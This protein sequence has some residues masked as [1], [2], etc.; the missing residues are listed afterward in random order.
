MRLLSELVRDERILAE[1]GDI[2]SYLIAI[3]SPRRGD[4]VNDRI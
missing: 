2:Y 4:S 1:N 3:A